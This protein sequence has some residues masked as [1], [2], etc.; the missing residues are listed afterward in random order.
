MIL[1]FK[2][3]PQANKADGLQDTF[4][5]FAR[6]FLEVLGYK[7]LQHPDRGADGK[8]DLIVQE[9]RQGLSGSTN[10]NWLVSCKHHAFSGKSVSDKDE[11][12]IQ[13]RLTTHNCN[14][15]IGFYSTLP[16]SGLGSIIQGLKSKVETQTFD[17]EQ[18]EKVLIE[19]PQGL[20]LTSRYFPKSYK[21]IVEEN[22]VPAKIFSGELELN[23]GYCGKN[24]LLEKKGLFVYLE[25]AKD[26]NLDE[27]GQKH[28]TKS[29][30]SC[31]GKHDKIQ[32]YRNTQGE[33]YLDYFIDIS[34]FSN[35]TGYIKKIMHW[36]NLFIKKGVVIEEEVLNMMKDLFMHTFPN[37]SREPTQAEKEKVKDY[38]SKGF[39]D[40]L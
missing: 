21:K 18:I 12:N 26:F 36:F 39:H 2:E 37:I 9:S 24:L 34:D 16:S 22:P 15:F 20:K 29:Y 7:I 27:I 31:Y 1:D 19:S 14:G 8:K 17:K 35:P 33:D 11:P 28:I 13:D 6:D 25:R 32:M 38:V 30:F 5:L 40:F 10:I 3:I 23:C 4:E